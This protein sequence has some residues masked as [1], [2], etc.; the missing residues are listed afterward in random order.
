MIFNGKFYS[1]LG[2][3]KQEMDEFIADEYDEY[4]K[5][6]KIRKKK[7]QMIE[8]RIDGLIST[9]QERI[10]IE[11]KF[12]DS[13]LEELKTRI[14]KDSLSSIEDKYIGLARRIDNRGKRINMMECFVIELKSLKEKE[15][16][17]H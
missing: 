1:K 13:E 4:V 3:T 9:Y 15:N 16:A 10:R 14:L 8:E 12:R 2:I 5:E 11:N 17:E 6:K 7:I